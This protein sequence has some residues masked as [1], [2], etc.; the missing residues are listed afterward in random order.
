MKTGSA[1]LARR[2]GL[3]AAAGATIAAAGIAAEL[4]H[5]VEDGSRV[6]NVPLF[7]LYVGSYG[8]GMALLVA[9]IV[10]LR[11]LHAAEGV[12][13][14]RAGRLGFRLATGGAAAQV[15]FASIMVASAVATGKTVGAAFI[16]FALGFL[17]L[18]VGQV[19]LAPGLRRGAVVG[20]GWIAPLA[21]VV[22][23]AIAIGTPID[24]LHDLALFLYF[25]SW[26]VLGAIVLI[27]GAGG[28]GSTMEAW[29]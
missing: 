9:A 14:G 7:V 11:R 13:I 10:G 3:A 1:P 2:C 6:E 28:R 4:L 5:R 22:T 18:I 17:A 21:G 12:E 15:A 20:R 16:L 8:V 26:V 24:P 27:R 23:A 19:L 29:S 25:G